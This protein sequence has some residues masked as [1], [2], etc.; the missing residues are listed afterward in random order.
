MCQTCLPNPSAPVHY[1]LSGEMLVALVTCVVPWRIMPAVRTNH[2]DWSQRAKDY[3]ASRRRLTDYFPVAS[4]RYNET[5]FRKEWTGLIRVGVGVFVHPTKSGTKQWVLPGKLG[6]WDNY[7]KTVNDCLVYAGWL[8][9]DSAR[10]VRGP[11]PIILP[12][13]F[14]TTLLFESGIYLF[15]K[16]VAKPDS[17]TVITIWSVS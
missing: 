2:N 9:G 13:E 3:Y 16:T 12:P 17:A 8:N 1:N 10:F 7:Q 5:F 15:P 4:K 6:D 11:A 14:N